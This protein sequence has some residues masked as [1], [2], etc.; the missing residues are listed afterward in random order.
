MPKLTSMDK[1]QT[2]LRRA[3]P[4]IVLIAAGCFLSACDSGRAAYGPKSANVLGIAEYEK[5]DYGYVG[6][7]TFAVS[8]DEL[9]PRRNYSGDKATFFWGLVTIKDY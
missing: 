6:P 4:V 7:N 2:A 1:P 9:Y 5:E 8:T 3:V